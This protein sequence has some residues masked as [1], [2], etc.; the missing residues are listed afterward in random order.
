M[1][2]Q[3]GP[4][5]VAVVLAATVAQ[6]IVGATGLLPQFNGKGFASRLI[7]YP[8]LMLVLPAIW[9]WRRRGRGRT[10]VP[11]TA[12]SLIMAPFLIDVTGNT[13]NLYDSIDW[14]DDANHFLN[15][16]LLL[17]GI[18]LLLYPGRIQDGWRT[19]LT[20]VGAGALLA[21]LWELG[22]YQVFIRR[23]VELDGAY[24]DTLGD[25][26]LGTLGALVAGLLVWWVR[27]DRQM[28]PRSRNASI[29]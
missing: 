3:W 1:R 22:E 25:E 17:S 28:R 23:G 12:W 5:V 26:A 29:D 14:W 15:W 7:A 4:V 19:V 11:W 10:E 21:I 6:L 20:I 13:L 2:R 24:Q 9:W 8:V 16:F 18:G 27:R